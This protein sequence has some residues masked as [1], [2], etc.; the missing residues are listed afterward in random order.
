MRHYSLSRA[1]PSRSSVLPR[2]LSRPAFPFSLPAWF[3]ATL[4]LVLAACGGGGGGNNGASGLSPAG[5][6]R[7]QA[8][9]H[10]A[11][12]SY[13]APKQATLAALVGASSNHEV[14]VDDAGNALIV[15][16]DTTAIGSAASTVR[17]VRY[18]VRDG[19]SAPVT[20]DGTPAQNSGID[21][22]MDPASGRAIASWRTVSGGHPNYQHH[23]LTATF[24]PGS[25]SWSAPRS[26]LG[27]AL[28][29][30]SGSIRSVIHG[31]GSVLTVW[32]DRLASGDT[33]AR[34]YS[35]QH[36]PK[37]QYG[38]AFAV[39]TQMPAAARDISFALAPLPGNGALLTW[40]RYLDGSITDGA[41]TLHGARFLDGAWKVTLLDDAA[42]TIAAKPLP[43][44]L[45][46]NSRGRG[47]LV[48]LHRGLEGNET[49]SSIV[50][51]G[52]DDGWLAPQTIGSELLSANGLG[53][54]SSGQPHVAVNEAASAVVLYA[55]VQA[56]GLRQ[57][58]ASRSPGDNGRLAALP[59]RALVIDAGDADSDRYSLDVT[60][61]DWGRSLAMWSDQ[62]PAA[63][64]APAAVEGVDQILLQGFDPVAGWSAPVRVDDGLHPVISSPAIA[65]NRYGDTVVVWSGRPNSLPAA[66]LRAW[67]RHGGS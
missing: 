1:V 38:P 47:S 67:V 66:E 10:V 60:L 58:R 28:S 22:A 36:G 55:T 3:G 41:R 8:S 39:D 26:P 43:S 20:I 13:A 51:R 19:W 56:D 32:Q 53:G 24:D 45:A 48:Y 33:W 54:A 7:P 23:A 16:M 18:T 25:G 6:D 40:S 62:R 31:D 57:L 50:V 34:L 12:P 4:V 5:R 11:A 14:A 2:Q 42:A 15:W 44:S 9:E 52:F 46:I 49:R 35:S 63:A 17:S 27:N 37:G 61:D 64:A 65:S 30:S 29:S 59:A 21:L